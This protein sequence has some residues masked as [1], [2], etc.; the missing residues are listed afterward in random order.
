MSRAESLHFVHDPAPCMVLPYTTASARLHSAQVG[1]VVPSSEQPVLA[2]A[3]LM[4]LSHIHAASF[5]HRMNTR[6]AAPT[7]LLN[8]FEG[9]TVS[10]VVPERARV[11]RGKGN[12]YERCVVAVVYSNH[13][14][15][16]IRQRMCTKR[17][18]TSSLPGLH[19]VFAGHGRHVY[20]FSGV[21]S[22]PHSFRTAR[23]ELL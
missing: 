6:L 7:A 12:A 15:P 9:R 13:A 19:T 10:K 23:Q 2:A 11:L 17:E 16:K 18:K 5:S 4:L 21:I 20:T 3:L 1:P 8:P 14:A 22:M